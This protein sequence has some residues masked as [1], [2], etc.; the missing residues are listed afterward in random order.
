MNRRCSRCRIPGHVVTH[1]PT[2]ALD[3]ERIESAQQYGVHLNLRQHLRQ[4]FSADILARYVRQRYGVISGSKNESIE[5][6]VHFGNR[7]DEDD[8]VVV[9]ERPSQG[10]SILNQDCILLDELY[11]HIGNDLVRQLFHR[12]YNQDIRTVEATVLPNI[13][14]DKSVP[15]VKAK[16]VDMF[17]KTIPI[18]TTVVFF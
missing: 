11:E 15:I 12:I 8:D 7:A 4:G 2:A 17:D 3:F 9:I 10:P 14:F 1:C 18:A 16:K 6:I 13:P 5:L